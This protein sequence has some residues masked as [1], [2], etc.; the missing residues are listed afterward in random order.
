MKYFLKENLYFFAHRFLWLLLLIPSVSFRRLLL[1]LCGAKV[2]DQVSILI[3]LKVLAPWHLTIQSGTTVNSNVLLDA[4]GGLKVGRNSQ[5]GYGSRI[6]SMGHSTQSSD[7]PAVKHAVNIGDN[8][9]IFSESYIGPG[10]SVGNNV[11]I[12]PRTV[13]YGKRLIDDN[14]RICGNPYTHLSNSTTELSSN[15]FNNSPLGL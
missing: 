12:Y 10:T 2:A 13:I 6:H 4:R 11:I 8:T 14:S 15:K 3:G 7:F 1:N 5:I 9:I